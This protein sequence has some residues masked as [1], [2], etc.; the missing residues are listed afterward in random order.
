MPPLPAPDGAVL[1]GHRLG[2]MALLDAR[3]GSLRWD[4]SSRTVAVR[5][6]P[7]GPGPNGWFVLPLHDGTVLF[8]GP[9][10]P[11]DQKRPPALV[12]G[13]AVGP[14]GLLLIGTGQGDENGLLAVTG[15]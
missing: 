3:T 7:A 9:D 13:V 5:G 4:A 8:A 2:G 14:G 15:W 6:G 11:V 12:T 10:R 1:V